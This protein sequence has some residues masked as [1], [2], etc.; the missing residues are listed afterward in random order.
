MLQPRAETEATGSSFVL[1]DQVPTGEVWLVP[2]DA[3]A[4]PR[5]VWTAPR[6]TEELVDLTWAPDEKH[7]TVVGR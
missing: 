5:R 6:P 2:T 3:G 4:T 7:L 1:F